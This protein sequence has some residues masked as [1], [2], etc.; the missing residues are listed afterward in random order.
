MSLRSYPDLI[1]L[2][3]SKAC[4]LLVITYARRPVL[5]DSQMVGVHGNTQLSPKQVT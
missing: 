5:V 1:A 4:S 2:A 3:A